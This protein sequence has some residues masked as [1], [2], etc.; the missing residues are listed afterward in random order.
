MYEPTPADILRSQLRLAAIRED[1]STRLWPVN[2]GMSSVSFNELMDQ[3]AVLQFC[4][5]R[6][7]CEGILDEDR[8]LGQLY[9]RALAVVRGAATEVEANAGDSC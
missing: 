2:Q 3:M 4:S 1:I 5:E 7:I 6:R 8:R 9:L